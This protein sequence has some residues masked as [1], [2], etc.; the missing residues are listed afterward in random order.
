MNEMGNGSAFRILALVIALSAPTSV[1]AQT[2]TR[3]LRKTDLIRL[4]TDSSLSPA[5]VA[6]QVGKS[7]LAFTPTARDRTNLVALGAPRPP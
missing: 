7:C 5:Q 6:A 2:E 3:P 1:G 4:L